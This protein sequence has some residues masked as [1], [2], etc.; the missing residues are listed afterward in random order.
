[1][2]RFIRY[3]LTLGAAFIGLSLASTSFALGDTCQDVRILVKNHRAQEINVTRVKYY[4]YDQGAYGTWRT[5]STWGSLKIAPGL[6]GYKYKTR[7][8]EHVKNDSTKVKIYW[9]YST[10]GNNW[11]SEYTLTSG[12]FTCNAGDDVWFNVY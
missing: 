12:T 1:M 10:G 9:K 7:D 4:D 3:T 8:L 6:A 5:E 2:L 11:S